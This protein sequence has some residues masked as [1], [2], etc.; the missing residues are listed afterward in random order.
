MSGLPPRVVVGSL[1]CAD[2]LDGE[3]GQMDRC[4]LLCG[5]TDVVVGWSR[6]ALLR[7]GSLD[8]GWSWS[9][10]LGLRVMCGLELLSGLQDAVQETLRRVIRYAY[11]T[12]LMDD[13]LD[14]V[15]LLGSQA[16]LIVVM[17]CLPTSSCRM[18][19]R[20]ALNLCPSTGQQQRCM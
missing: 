15:A 11:Q 1:V 3:D 6:D 4:W 16:L 7:N 14:P 5:E 9:I 13:A 18:A 17:F 2:G 19:R 8:L 10:E 20:E 12:N